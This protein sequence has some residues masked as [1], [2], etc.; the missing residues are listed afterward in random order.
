[1]NTQRLS[2][3]NWRSFCGTLLANAPLDNW[4]TNFLRSVVVRKQPTTKQKHVIFKLVLKHIPAAVGN[5]GA[6]SVTEKGVKE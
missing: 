3:S 6:T 1:M 2:A 5:W 4:Q